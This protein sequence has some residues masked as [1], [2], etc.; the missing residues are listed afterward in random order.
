MQFAMKYLLYPML[1]HKPSANLVAVPMSITGQKPS[2]SLSYC[3]KKNKIDNPN[4]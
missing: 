4:I 2:G 1:E 3:I